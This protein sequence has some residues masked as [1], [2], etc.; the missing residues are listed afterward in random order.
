M[1]NYFCKILFFFV[2]VSFF[3]S[4]NHYNGLIVDG[5]LYVLQVINTMHPER[6]VGD[7]AFAYGNQDSFSLFTPIYRFFIVHF[8]VEAGSRYLCFIMQGLF[9]FAWALVIKV[10]WEKF[11]IGA[12]SL[13]KMNRSYG[14]FSNVLNGM[15]FPMALCLLCM[16]VYAFGMPLTQTE[17][18][19]FVESYAVSRQPSIAFGIAGLAYLLAERK[20][21]S[22]VLFVIGSLMHPLMA[23]WGLPLWLFVYYPKSIKFVVAGSILLPLTILLGKVPFSSYP[24]GWLTRPF[25]FAPTYDDIAKFVTFIAFFCVCAK[26]LQSIC[27]RNVSKAIAVVV[28]I[29]LYWWMW[30]GFAHHIFLYQVQCFRIEWICMVLVVPFFVLIA[31]ER[32]QRLHVSRNLFIHDFALISFA[33]ALFLPMHLMEFTILG[34]VL[35]FME[36]RKLS[37]SIPQVVFLLTSLAALCYQTY[38]RLSLE[39][40]P[41]IVLRNMSDAYRIAD[42]LVMAECVMAVLVAVYM[43]K[44]KKYELIAALIMFLFFLP[45]QLLPLVVSLIWMLPKWNRG[46]SCVLLLVAIVEGIVNYGDRIVH[47]S[48]PGP[49]AEVLVLFVCFAVATVMSCF[50]S[51]KHF[52]RIIPL[53]IFAFATAA[54]ACVHWDTRPAE[55]VASEKQIDSFIDKDIFENVDAPNRGMVFYHVNGFAACMP[56]L[57]FL[58]GGYYDENSLTGALFFEGQYRDGNHRRNM[59]LLKR[60]DGT[61]SDYASYRN[62]A[63]GILA[64]KDSL[65][66]RVDFLCSEGE[67]S[68]VVSDTKLPYLPKDSIWLDVIG[69]KAYLY[70]CDKL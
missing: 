43:L 41:L 64:K 62:F 4:V 5:P 15:L 55:M 46:V 10:I 39:G 24:E 57:Q 28:S 48:Y 11:V 8:G 49:L 25:N 40:L 47:V 37:L 66:D 45:M 36:D 16:G 14:V 69:K 63:N 1:M 38:L 67:I 54:Y 13:L 59:L 65:L 58:N 33:I 51:Q 53:I 44:K 9:A 32:C 18:I 12:F 23:G 20:I 50:L 68:H 21:V 42:T 3:Y 26:R 2:A 52:I 22:L 61:Q 19:R 17:F 60:D 29:A 34:T 30:G 7:I 27:A 31:L 35:F 6:F 70:S 56:R